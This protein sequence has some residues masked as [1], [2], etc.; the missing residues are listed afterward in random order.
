MM[1]AQDNKQQHNT[2]FLDGQKVMLSVD[3]LLAG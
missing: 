1:L 3:V 2:I